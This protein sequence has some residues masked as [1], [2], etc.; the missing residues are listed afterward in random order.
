VATAVVKYP[1]KPWLIVGTSREG[2]LLFN[3][4]TNHFFAQYHHDPKNRYSLSGNNIRK[5]HLDNRHNIFIAV[6]GKG[7]DYGNLHQS[8]FPSLTP[9]LQPPEL[10]HA[11]VSTLLKC[12]N[13]NVLC[14]TRNEG[15]IVYNQDMKGVLAHLLGHA[16]I[17]R[18]SPLSDKQIMV[19]LANGKQ[20]AYDVNTSV[21]K[22]LKLQSL[23]GSP[24]RFQMNQIEKFNQRVYAATEYGLGEITFN[25]ERITLTLDKQFN[26]TLHWPNIQQI[27][28]ISPDSLLVQT[29]Y[30]ALYLYVYQNHKFTSVREICRTPYAIN[31][32]TIANRKLYLATTQGLL[33]MSIS[34]LAEP[35]KLLESNCSGLVYTNGAIWTVGN[36]GL[37]K[38]DIKHK[39]TTYFSRRD[40][41][42]NISFAPQTMVLLNP[43]LMVVGSDQGINIFNPNTLNPYRSTA[44]PKITDFT[45]NNEHY[46][47]AGNPVMCK[48][49]TLEDTE[50]T[51]SIAF[52][53]MDYIAPEKREIRYRM[54]GYDKADII[55]F[56]NGLVRYPNMPAGN[57]RFELKDVIS[58]TV[59]FLNIQV[60]APFWQK[61]WFIT[62]I[63]AIL[64]VLCAL[65]L[66]FYL[67]WINQLQSSQLRQ[68]INFQKSDRKRIADELHDDLG[69]KLSSLKHYLI[70]GD[71][72]KMIDRGMLRA[73]A[74]E[75]I[76][77]ALSVLRSTLINLS[78]KTL[79]QEGL[80]LA[81]ADLMESISHTPSLK[82]HFDYGSFNDQLLSTQQYA[83]YRICQ[84]LLN[85]TLK[86]SGAK[87]IYLSIVSFP[88]STVLLYEDDGKG[89][90]YEQVKRGYGLYNMEAYVKAIRADLDI[91]SAAGKGMAV[92]IIVENKTRKR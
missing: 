65:S 44:Q 71:I 46:K 82:I 79:D 92:T 70:A 88:N 83:L 34:N 26:S 85:N 89:F 80:I 16:E 51:F 90:D 87:N 30:T 73:L 23:P 40:G 29:Y 69:I 72:N 10:A 86:H 60:L 64:L 32:S 53:S 63:S 33:K 66:C 49:I 8:V 18:L 74:T 78:P 31:E 50:N 68:M 76:D 45:V 42:K 55:H 25:K 37:F 7:L 39:M 84:E 27:I 9:N 1:N 75:Y 28:P 47:L 6:E 43:N 91:Q 57:Y 52:S 35:V 5:I 19:E 41:L 4:Q 48:K 14:G 24:T 38:Y 12:S 21:L 54:I 2:I 11:D 13:G 20:Y 56:G 61:W 22:L 3:L 59:T 58:G 17:K 77:G 36:S 62:A 81:L 67:R 15:L